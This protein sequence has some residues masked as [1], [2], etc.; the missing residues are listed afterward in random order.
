MDKAPRISE[1]EW[2]VMKVVWDRHPITANEVVEALD[3]THW[4]D[5]TIRT[6]INRLVAKGALGFDKEGRVY[7][8]YPLLEK[9]RSVR[10]EGKSF[11]RRVYDGAVTPMLVHFI[12]S[13]ELSP[14]EIDGLRQLLDKKRR[15]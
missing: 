2:E 4:Q 12:E 15:P 5:K 3:S 7:H 6:L 13:E 14:Q 10:G 8:Y 1:A 9:S 11:L